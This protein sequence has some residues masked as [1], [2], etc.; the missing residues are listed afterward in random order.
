MIEYR[1]LTNDEIIEWVNPVCAQRGWAQL[2]VNDAQPTCRVRGAFD[3]VAF[4]AFIVVQLFPV[5]GPE[6]S[7]TAHRDG[8]I[9]R[10]LADQMHDY[11][12]EVKAR[13]ALTICES[14]VSERL[15]QRHGMTEI[16]EPVYMWV[17]AR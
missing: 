8:T 11:L 16:T 10:E 5:V 4:V 1:W 7:D 17:G 13:G 9:S 15:A 6:W 12:V 3:G 2:N 14:P